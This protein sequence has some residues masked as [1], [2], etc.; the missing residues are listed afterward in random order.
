MSSESIPGFSREHFDILTGITQ[1]LFSEI[2]SFSDIWN[3]TI[4]A[5]LRIGPFDSCPLGNLVGYIQALRATCEQG[6]YAIQCLKG[7]STHEA[8]NITE[9]YVAYFLN[10]FIIRVKTGTDLL[11]LMIKSIY[12]LGIDDKKC[13]LESGSFASHLRS[14]ASSCQTAESLARE[15][16]RVRTEWLGSFDTLRDLAVHRAGFKFMM[17]GGTEYPVHIELPLPEAARSQPIPYDLS[18]P[19][20]ALKPYIPDEPLSQ[21]LTQIG[22]RSVSKYLITMNPILF[23][24]EVWKLW[25]K[26]TDKI[27]SLCREDLLAQF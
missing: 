11:A 4:Q 16:D 10:D 1:R 23:C 12:G 8:S 9:F 3:P 18:D 5:G 15:I 19:L 20:R 25:S 21:F 24:E 22:S 13:S 26:S 2:P 14:T 17:V 6:L 7:F 27:L